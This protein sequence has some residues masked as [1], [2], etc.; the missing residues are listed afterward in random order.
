MTCA[1]APIGVKDFAS[2]EGCRLEVKDR[3]NDVG[4]FAH[5]AD[6]VQGIEL[7]IRV[8][9]VHRRFDDPRR[10]GVHPSTA[11]C[12]LDRE[13]FGRGGQAALRKRGCLRRAAPALRTKEIKVDFSRERPDLPG[14]RKGEVCRMISIT[15]PLPDDANPN[16][17]GVPT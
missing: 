16:F 7:R 5:M 3:A 13:R 14:G 15:A 17:A 6:G 9:G 1:L 4:D 8:D 11:P 2:H 10:D 12:I